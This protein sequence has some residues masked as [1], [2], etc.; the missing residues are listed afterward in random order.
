MQK[1]CNWLRFTVI[2]TIATAIIFVC[3]FFLDAWVAQNVKSFLHA[4]PR[5]EISFVAIP[6]LLPLVVGAGTAG[7]GVAYLVQFRRSDS[8]HT[9]FLKLAMIVVPV[10]YV[11]KMF[12]QYVFGRT[13]TRL[14]MSK[15]DEMVFSCF[16]PL[17]NYPC[18]PSGHMTVFTAF[19]TAVWMFYPQYR[20]VTIV[21]LTILG[22]AL[23]V[24]NYHYLGDVLAGFFCG[25]LITAIT[26]HFIVKVVTG[27]TIC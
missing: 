4:S 23:V 19:F 26:S 17:S 18:F 20:L 12:L 25:V 9:I 5:L 15:G 7:L 2:S 27:K 3:I 10:A 13:S 16:T 24:T 21:F 22:I 14:W 8:S 6:N 11:V 1:P